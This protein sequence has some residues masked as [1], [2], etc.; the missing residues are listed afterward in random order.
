MAGEAPRKLEPDGPDPGVGGSLTGYA[1]QRPLELGSAPARNPVRLNSLVPPVGDEPL[2][3]HAALEM[4]TTRGP[5]TQ[6]ST[7][8]LNDQ[9][10]SVWPACGAEGIGPDLNPPTSPE[11]SGRPEVPSGLKDS[12]HSDRWNTNKGDVKGDGTKHNYLMLILLSPT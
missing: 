6:G 3:H 2:S 9:V 5:D 4:R 7:R 12:S 1:G 10:E 8:L 11:G